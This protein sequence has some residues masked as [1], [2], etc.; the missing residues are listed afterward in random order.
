M[1]RR[2][3][4][5]IRSRNF[6][7]LYEFLMKFNVFIYGMNPDESFPKGRSVSIAESAEMLETVR[8]FGLSPQLAPLFDLEARAFRL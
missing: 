1:S 6:R 5:A 3:V 4:R 2:T 8:G 7:H